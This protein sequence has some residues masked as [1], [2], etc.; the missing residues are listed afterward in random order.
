LNC[1]IRKS[2]IRLLFKARINVF[3]ALSTGQL[4]KYTNEYI[5]EVKPGFKINLREEVNNY[6]DEKIKF[7]KANNLPED[8]GIINLDFWTNTGLKSKEVTIEDFDS[9][10][11][12]NFNPLFMIKDTHAYA[13]KYPVVP[14]RKDKWKDSMSI[15]GASLNNMDNI[16]L[17]LKHPINVGEL[18]NDTK[19][20]IIVRNISSILPFAETKQGNIPMVQAEVLVPKDIA[21]KLKYPIES[22]KDGNITTS[23]VDIKNYDNKFLGEDG[24]LKDLTNDYIR[25][26]AN[27]SDS[28]LKDDYVVVKMMVPYNDIYL[29]MLED[30]ANVDIDPKY[31]SWI[32]EKVNNITRQKDEQT[33]I[34]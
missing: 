13:M 31:F 7:N 20:K 10:N 9:G 14:I 8:Q 1:G 16:Y 6:N 27:V 4:A 15:Y 12:N 3:T 2:P 21:K 34:R 23:M 17:D 28:E 19:G 25:G 30:D 18:L 11:W 24:E 33:I 29:D 22:M 26:R 5:S 32:Q